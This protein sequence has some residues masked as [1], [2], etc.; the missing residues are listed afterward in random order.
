MD[1]NNDT[2]ELGIIKDD[3]FW[4]D[5]FSILYRQDRVIEFVPTVD[6]SNIERLNAI[7]RFGIYSGVLLALFNNKVWPLYISVFVLGSTLFVHKNGLKQL[8]GFLGFDG[9]TFDEVKKKQMN[10]FGEDEPVKTLEDGTVCS[11]PTYNNPF[12]NVLA[13]EYGDNPTK[14]PACPTEDTLDQKGVSE[15]VEKKFNLNLYKDVSDLFERN[16][17]QRQFYTNP[18]TTVPNDQGGFAHWLYGNAPSCKDDR[19]DC[20]RWV[21]ET[22]RR[23]RPIFPDPTRNPVTTKRQEAGLVLPAGQPV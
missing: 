18:A 4:G 23:S 7:A 12:M 20:G 13:N 3:P 11:A 8:E 14:P 6:M 16:N 21:T 1:N 19:Y 10:D 9:V 2:P 5:D 17:G 15:E 22:T